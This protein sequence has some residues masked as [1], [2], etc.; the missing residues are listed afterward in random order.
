M[1]LDGSDPRKA[2]PALGWLGVGEDAV[3]WVQLGGEA[4]G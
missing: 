4:G 2:C 3:P 1:L